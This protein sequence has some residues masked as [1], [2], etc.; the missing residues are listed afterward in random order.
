MPGRRA[1]GDAVVI[2]AIEGMAGAAPLLPGTPGCATLITSRHSL[3]ELAPAT[4]LTMDVFTAEEAQTFLLPTA[5]TKADEEAA[6]R[7]AHRCGRLPLA[8]S[9][10]AGHIRRTPG[11][12]LTDHADRLDER[13]ADRRLENGVEAALDLSYLRLPTD[14]RA[15]LRR[16]ALHPGQDFDAYA[17]AALDD[18]D[19]LTAE[20]RLD[21]LRADHVLQAA[22]PGRYAFHDLVR[23]YAIGRARDEDPPGDRRATLDRLLDHYLA[24]SAAAVT[25]LYGDVTRYLQGRPVPPGAVPDPRLAEPGAARDWL[26]TE[27]PN[28]IAAAAQ[29]SA[30]HTVTLARVLFLYLSGGHHTDALAVHGHAYRVAVR[31]GDEIGQ[32]HALTDLGVA[33]FWLSQHGEA[34]AYHRRA[35]EVFRRTGDQAGEARALD[36]LGMSLIKPGRYEEA[37]GV[38]HQALTLYRL[39]GDLEGRGSSLCALGFVSLHRG[40]FSAAAGF[41]IEAA[42]QARSLGIRSNEAY[43]LHGL[44]ET[45]MRLGRLE[46][47]G[48]HLRQALETI[49]QS[50]HRDAESDVI[51]TIGDLCIRMGRP[52]EGAEHHRRALAV[53]RVTG[54]R[55]GQALSLNGLGDA[56]LA[57]GRPDDAAEFYA[58]ALVSATESD[59]RD[60]VVRARAGLVRAREKRA[61]RIAPGMVRDGEAGRARSGGES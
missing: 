33:H 23:A 53:A 47:A 49:R 57:A 3:T 41:F 6:A 35:R 14:I 18:S 56:A 36:C 52:D 58:E 38:L 10:V 13:H 11:W 7:I 16:L 48:R 45:E 27:R 30:A 51:A 9:L 60:E 46:A 40:E 1:R 39:A 50:G 2:S 25:T 29:E 24:T 17:A 43:A 4:H 26:D 32:G 44:G 34:A 20:G 28:L 55:S 5:C 61:N 8:L 31:T 42:D 54:D 37:A 12:T 59:T 19:L 21:R 15:L 22:A